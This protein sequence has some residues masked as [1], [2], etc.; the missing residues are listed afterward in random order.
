MGRSKTSGTRGHRQLEDAS[1]GFSTV[2]IVQVMGRV[3]IK[4]RFQ[5]IVE[6]EVKENK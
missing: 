4:G 6:A 1:C 3:T 5:V 2:W